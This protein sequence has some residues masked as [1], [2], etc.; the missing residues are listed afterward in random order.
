MANW[1]GMCIVAMRGL[2]FENLSSF[3]TGYLKA[4]WKTFIEHG[5]MPLLFYQE[6]ARD[7]TL[8]KFG[9]KLLPFIFMV[10]EG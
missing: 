3:S 7:S 10:I 1:E 6:S 5:Y 8:R 4:P 9:W 2:S